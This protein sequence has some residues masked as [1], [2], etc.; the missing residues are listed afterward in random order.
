V[1][2]YS[3]CDLSPAEIKIIEESTKYNYKEQGKTL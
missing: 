2:V 3:L 1:A